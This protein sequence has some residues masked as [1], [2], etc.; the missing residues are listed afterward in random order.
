MGEAYT[1]TCV[2]STQN[3]SHACTYICVR[4]YRTQCVSYAWL[5]ATY[6]S[7]YHSTLM[8]LSGLVQLCSPPWCSELQ[9]FQRFEM[10]ITFAA[11]H[12][13]SHNAERMESSAGTE[14]LLTNERGGT[15]RA[16]WRAAQQLHDRASAQGV[17]ERCDHEVTWERCY[18]IATTKC[19]H[20]VLLT[21]R[22]F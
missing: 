5:A 2:Y 3:I 13:W 20:C 1:C 7:C 9:Q 10:W 11:R 8:S 15:V 18:R 6:R 4:R 12:H 16:A 14:W 19:C 17:F 22:T 21:Y